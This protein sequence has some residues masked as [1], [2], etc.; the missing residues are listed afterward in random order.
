MYCYYEYIYKA[1]VSQ[2]KITFLDKTQQVS[3]H[4]KV[5]YHPSSTQTTPT[6]FTLIKIQ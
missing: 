3:I 6:P 2:M 5:T 1:F 4:S